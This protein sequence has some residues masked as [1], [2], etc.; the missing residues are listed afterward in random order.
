MMH[1]LLRAQ[2]RKLGL[3]TRRLPATPVQWTALLESIEG[4]YEAADRERRALE[5]STTSA[6]AETREL[7]ERMR[8]ST[9]ERYR[10]LFEH[11]NDIIYT[12]D[13]E[14]RFTTLNRAAE[15]AVGY[16]RSEL[17][18]K[19]YS[20]IVAPEYVDL[21]AEMTRRKV[22][23]RGPVHRYEIDIIDRS[24]VRRTVELNTRLVTRDGRPQEVL[25]LA[26]DVSERR[27]EER[28]LR[29]VAEHDLLTGLPNRLVLQRALQDALEGAQGGRP[30]VLAFVDL[31]NFK[32]V[33]DSLG[34]AAGDGVLLNVATMLRSRIR[35]GDILVRLG[36]DEFAI[37]LRDTGADDALAVV[38]RLRV[39]VT[40]SPFVARGQSFELGVSIGL[41]L[42]GAGD[43]PETVLAHADSAMYEAKNRG[44]NQVVLSGRPLRTVSG[45][46]APA[47][48]RLVHVVYE[49][50][51]R[52]AD[53]SVAHYVARVI[54]SDQVSPGSSI[55]V[56]RDREVIRTVI[57]ALGREPA[58]VAFVAL[59]PAG[60]DNSRLAGEILELLEQDSSIA[61]RAG[62]LLRRETPG[63]GATDPTEWIAR[64]RR[65][66]AR[67]A[68]RGLPSGLHQVLE[69]RLEPAD[70]VTIDA[71]ALRSL[72]LDPNRRALL[73]ASLA[74]LRDAGV[75]LIAGSLREPADLTR[76]REFKIPL[77]HGP[78]LAP[79][80][81]QPSW[82]GRLAA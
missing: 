74:I 22:T 70:L 66:G 72:A 41:C 4:A 80:L 34:H 19:H 63:A 54:P 20:M 39:A 52:L 82:D 43:A 6:S 21:V 73:S 48:T 25:G 51:F 61:R 11:A 16:D 27:E 58:A 26:R 60:Q 44:G 65:A 49:P 64:L 17:I 81:D 9:E 10:N 56:H 77:A 3:S 35:P 78:H 30:S 14:G 40:E 31:D 1:K 2:L 75:E 62:F 57:A 69:G 18:G 47:D 55:L 32:A 23:G 45:P 59:S 79:A 36:G 53:G 37:L 71:T 28:Q 76:V 46:L 38:D 33:N 5:E 8:V 12:V 50:V 42:I 15:L 29:H 67:L 24:G 13:L 68:F 7:Y